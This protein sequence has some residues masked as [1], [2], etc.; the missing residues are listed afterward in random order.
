MAKE[1]VMDSPS[2]QVQTEYLMTLHGALGPP[3]QVD[4]GLTIV[5]VPEGW[6]KGPR[7]SA[8]IVAPSGDWIQA[9][10]SGLRRLDVRLT[11]RTDDGAIISI[12]YNGVLRI[13]PQNADRFMKGEPLTSKDLYSST[14]PTFRTS[15]PKYIWLTQSQAV[16]KLVELKRGNHIRWD[17][18]AVT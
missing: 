13:D 6:A 11:L 1:I 17:V 7:I 9:L 15:H 12:N 8:A 10:P 4:D 5:N 16:A 18:F 14:A 3:M 2:V